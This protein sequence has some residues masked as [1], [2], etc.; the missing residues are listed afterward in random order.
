MKILL[1]AKK[2]GTVKRIQDALKEDGHTCIIPAAEASVCRKI[3]P[4]SEWDFILI[5]HHLPLINAITAC[6]EIRKQNQHIPVILIHHADGVNEITEGFNAGA[7]DC[8]LLPFEMNELRARM[9][10]LLKRKAGSM[11]DDDKILTYSDLEINLK[12]R[13]VR[14]GGKEISLTPREFSLLEYMVRNKEKILSREELAQNVWKSKL[15]SKVNSIDVYI[16][17]LRK[18]IDNPFPTK[19][20]HT[21]YWVGYILKA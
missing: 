8:L 14:R 2:D 3:T 15:N 21:K 4:N 6:K 13:I 17:Y 5:S 11:P 16:M 20:I 7:D 1:I 18:K 12:S 9:S 10:V 19:L